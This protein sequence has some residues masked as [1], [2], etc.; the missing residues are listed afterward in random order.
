MD[1]KDEYLRMGKVPATKTEEELKELRKKALASPKSQ[2][3]G[4]GGTVACWFKDSGGA[5]QC[6]PMDSAASCTAAGGV[7]V[8]GNCPN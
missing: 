7:P 5:D 6:I 4:G 3:V 8:S 1:K 2:A